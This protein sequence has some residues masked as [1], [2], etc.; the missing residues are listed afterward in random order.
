MQYT[1]KIMRANTFV[2]LGFLL[3]SL[4]AIVGYRFDRYYIANDYTVDVF[5]TCDTSIH[6]CFISDASVADPTYQAEPY[7]KVEINA[8][9]APYC[10]EEHTC[11]NFSCGTIASCTIAYCTADTT[12]S[13]ESCSSLSN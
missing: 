6:N 2:F 4:F 13:G 5:T 8:G 1:Y 7:E 9:D 10:L 3:L 12:D 11:T